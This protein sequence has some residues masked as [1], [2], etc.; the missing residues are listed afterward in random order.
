M[1][2]FEKSAWIMIAALVLSGWFYFQ[3]VIAMSQAIGVTAPPNVGLIAV[4]TV[5]IVSIAIFGHIIAAVIDPA[6]ADAPEDE[7]DTRIAQRAGNLAGWVL[8]IVVMGGIWSFAVRGDG[9]MLFHILVLGMVVS[10]IAEY[11]LKIWF[12]RR[13]V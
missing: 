11:A 1:T 5:V 3:A 8:S 9:N 4:A 6:S 13:G 10:Q 12:Y 7:R 2:F